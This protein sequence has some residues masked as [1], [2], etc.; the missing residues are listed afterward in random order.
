M[1]ICDGYHPK[2]SGQ[3][4]ARSE[5]ESEVWLQDTSAHLFERS[6]DASTRVQVMKFINV[7][8]SDQEMILLNV[9][10][11]KCEVIVVTKADRT[12]AFMQWRCAVT[13]ATVPASSSSCAVATVHDANEHSKEQRANAPEKPKASEDARSPG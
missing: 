3:F 1:L 9:Q 7:P 12:S 6:T 4:N 11:L 2:L 10:K 5:H 13:T 8:E